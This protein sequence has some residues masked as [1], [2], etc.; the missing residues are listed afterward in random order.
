MTSTE[1]S[2][3][4]LA[5]PLDG[6][7]LMHLLRMMHAETGLFP[8]SETRVAAILDAVLS[9]QQLTS[10]TIIGVIGN[11]SDLQAT[12]CLSVGNVYYTDEPHVGDMWN[13]VRPDCRRST[14]AKNLLEFGKKCADSMGMAFMSGVVSTERTEAKMRLYRRRFGTP[15]GGYFI[16]RQDKLNGTA[17]G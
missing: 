6:L 5:N 9:K 1:V 7:G 16:Y 11:P 13:F 17:H 8:F 4:R 15:I 12:I 14:H 10:P 3:V 2:P